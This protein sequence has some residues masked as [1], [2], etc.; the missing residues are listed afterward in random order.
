M[1]QHTILVVEDT[2]LL[3]RIY[4][5][6]LTQEGHNVLV[7]GDGLAALN[8]VRSEHVDLILLDLI[9]PT[10]SG[11]EALEAFKA[12]PR[13]RDIPVLILSNLGQEGDIERGLAMG[14]VD[15]LIKNEAK[16]ADVAEKIRLTLGFMADRQ[17]ANS[18]YR[19]A[20]RDR[21]ADA[22]RFIEDTKLIRRLWCP[23]CEVEFV[24]EL[25][26]KPTQPGWYDAHLL[27]PGCGK[28]HV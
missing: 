8:I 23:A 17:G 19:L 27:C 10:M 6:K 26:P 11:L 2:E 1:A 7:A 24:L 14:A 3:R 15:Y 4:A 5:D 13:T 9:M 18:A 21:E 22:D 25:L 16:P 20:I 12:D 28:E